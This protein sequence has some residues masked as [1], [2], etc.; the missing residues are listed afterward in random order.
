MN[1]FQSNWETT[2]RPEYW[3]QRVP[4]PTAANKMNPV[5]VFSD[6]WSSPVAVSVAKAKSLCA[7]FSCSDTFSQSQRGFKRR[8]FVTGNPSRFVS[9]VREDRWLTVGGIVGAVLGA[10]AFVGVGLVR[11]EYHVQDVGVAGQS[12]GRQFPTIPVKGKG[13]V[14]IGCCTARIT[15]YLSHVCAGFTT[16]GISRLER[17]CLKRNQDTS[18]MEWRQTCFGSAS[19]SQW[20]KTDHSL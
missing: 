8:R 10:E 16:T 3:K 13:R 17:W 7:S 4:W 9:V 6:Q 19:W 2:Y 1:P 11:V 18:H 12:Q 15:D 20:D 5:S 14:C